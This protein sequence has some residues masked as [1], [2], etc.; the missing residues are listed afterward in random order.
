MNRLYVNGL[1][2]HFTSKETIADAVA[3]CIEQGI[4]NVDQS[5]AA[6]CELCNEIDQTIEYNRNYKAEQLLQEIVVLVDNKIFCWCDI[7]TLDRHL[8]DARCY[9]PSSFVTW[10][11]LE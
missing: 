9:Y 11:Y 10:G 3:E 4:W 2:W 5:A 6:E 8:E 7:T 1:I